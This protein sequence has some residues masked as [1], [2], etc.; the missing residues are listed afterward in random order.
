MIKSYTNV[1]HQRRIK[2]LF[3]I[4]IRELSYCVFWHYSTS[5]VSFKCNGSKAMPK[6]WN[7]LLLDSLY[8]LMGI[9]LIFL[10]SYMGKN[11]CPL[12]CIC[13]CTR[14]LHLLLHIFIMSCTLAWDSCWLNIHQ[15]QILRGLKYSSTFN[16]YQR[17]ALAY[18]CV[19]E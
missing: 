14:S 17:S 5:L 9:L 2:E 1:C 15:Y 12:R 16:I 4:Y 13:W 19:V 10:I 6:I 3:I 11:K 18:N 8:P 7:I